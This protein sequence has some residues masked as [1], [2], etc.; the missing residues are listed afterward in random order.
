[1]S[2]PPSTTRCTSAGAPTSAAARIRRPWQPSA[3][4]EVVSE[5]FHTTVSPHTSATQVFHDHTA[6]GK[7]KAV[8]TP[9][10]P[11]GC[12]VS[13][14]RCPGRSEGMVRPYS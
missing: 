13:I 11:S 5:G 6:T 1:M 2:A 7:L 12:Q 9:T 8:M 3:V 4:S 10:T 14:R